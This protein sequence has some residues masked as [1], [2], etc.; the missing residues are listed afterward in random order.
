MGYVCNTSSLLAL[1]EL[2]LLCASSFHSGVRRPR[3]SAPSDLV[4]H[5]YLYVDNNENIQQILHH[6][7]RPCK[8]PKAE[9]ICQTTDR[10]LPSSRTVL[11]DICWK[12]LG[13]PS[14][15]RD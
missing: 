1:L 2:R 9:C 8:I 3:R 7:V 13:R 11:H 12:T 15:Q 14:T 4:V 10:N 6:V 5:R